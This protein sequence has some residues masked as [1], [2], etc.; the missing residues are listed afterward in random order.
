MLWFFV[1]ILSKYN[2]CVTNLML[3]DDFFIPFQTLTIKGGIL[4]IYEHVLG[5]P[6]FYCIQKQGWIHD[7][8]N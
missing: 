8:W 6:T 4:K 5:R 1:D 3:I 7:V 2:D